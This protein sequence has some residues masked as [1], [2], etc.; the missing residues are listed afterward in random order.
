MHGYTYA[1]HPVA[2]A[3]GIASLKIVREENLPQNAAVM[4][5]YLL[6]KLKPFESRYRA[7]GE[8]RGKG[9]MLALDLVKDRATREPIDPQDGY[10]NQVAAAARA[11]GALVRPVGT[12]II[13]SPPLVLQREHADLLVEALD[14]AFRAV[15]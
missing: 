7:V 5:T 4:G 8:V 1:G 3:A 15:G 11:A 2:C 6:E 10:A 13:L 12:K 14:T 9:L